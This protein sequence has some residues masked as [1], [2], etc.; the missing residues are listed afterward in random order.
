MLLSHCQLLPYRRLAY[1]PED[2]S[3]RDNQQRD[4][5][6]HT[7]N[8]PEETNE[9]GWDKEEDRDFTASGDDYD[10]DY[11]YDYDTITV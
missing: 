7:D 6:A 5:E 4:L 2:Q 8:A 3:L 10:Y 9:M 11:D 1:P